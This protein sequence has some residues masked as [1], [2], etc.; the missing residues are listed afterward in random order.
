MVLNHGEREAFL[1]PTGS[2][3]FEDVAAGTH[4]VEVVSPD[5]LYNALRVEVWEDVLVRCL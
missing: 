5:Y 4:L 3:R 1:S 2:F